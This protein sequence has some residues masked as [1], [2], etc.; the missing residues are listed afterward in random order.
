MKAITCP[1]CGSL[2][3]TV[4]LPQVLVECDYCG[5]KITPD[6]RFAT[7]GPFDVEAEKFR[8]LEIPAGP[9]TATQPIFIAISLIGVFSFV[10][11]LAALLPTKSRPIAQAPDESYKPVVLPT[12]TPVPR[13]TG[14]D[15]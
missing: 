8:A 10:L 7:A 1:Q 5:A 14:D 6:E 11:F 12:I 2:I 9:Q 15:R 3:K 4:L 13:K